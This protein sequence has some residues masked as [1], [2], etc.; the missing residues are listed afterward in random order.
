MPVTALYAGLL[1]LLFVVLSFRVSGVRR[2]QKISVGDGGNSDLLRRMRVHGN[3]AEYV[4]LVLVLMGLAESLK[5]Q[6]R[7]LHAIG[8]ALLVG[9]ILHVIGL[10]PATSVLPLRAGGMILTFLAMISAAGLCL[11]A[12][13]ASVS[14][15]P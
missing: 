10:S 7:L 5:T 4:P 2:S 12:S 3:F 9:R 14:F 1:A 6:P 11:M 8:A 13:V 15:G